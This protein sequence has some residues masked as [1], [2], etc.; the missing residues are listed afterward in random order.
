[1]SKAYDSVHIPLLQHALTRLKIPI[2]IQQLIINIHNNRFN[3]VITN[4]GPT[5]SYH[6][7]DGIDQGETITPL[8]WR[9]YYDPLITYI[10]SKFQ[11]YNMSMT[12]LP[13]TQHLTYHTS[14]LAY[15]DDILWLAPNKH[16]L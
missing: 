7:Q 1:M 6:V 8:L 4:F 15:M 5:S 13:N 16:T 9:I 14:V 12:S 10:H 3:S 11:G 2:N